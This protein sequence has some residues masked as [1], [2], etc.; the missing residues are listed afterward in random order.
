MSTD[1]GAAADLPLSVEEAESGYD[2]F[3]RKMRE[4]PLVPIG[5]C[6]LLKQAACSLVAP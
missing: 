2:K 3:F 4:D 1:D 6:M 5:R